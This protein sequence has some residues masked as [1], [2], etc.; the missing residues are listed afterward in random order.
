M[1][2][3]YQ[4]DSAESVVVEHQKIRKS[5]LD[6]NDHCLLQVC[7]YLD[8]WDV[9]YLSRVCKKLHAVCVSAGLQFKYFSMEDYC[10]WYGQG[11]YNEAKFIADMDSVMG[12]ICPF[13]E[14]LDFSNINDD[15]AVPY[16]FEKFNFP[17]LK[18]LAIYKSPQL[19]WI[20]NMDSI[21]ALTI[22]KV[23]QSDLREFVGS[24]T[25]LKR[26]TLRSI[27]AEVHTSEVCSF[28]EQNPN[29]ECL[30][31]G[32]AL[33]DSVGVDFFK[34]FKNL[35]TLEFV[36]GNNYRDLNF[37]LQ[38]ERL[39]ELT[40]TLVKYDMT[41]HDDFLQLIAVAN[42][43]KTFLRLLSQKKTLKSLDLKHMKYDD[44]V[45]D[46]LA[47]LNLHF[48]RMVDH[49]YINNGLFSMQLQRQSFETLRR[50]DITIPIE[51]ETLLHLIRRSRCLKLMYL[52]WVMSY[53]PDTL[54]AELIRLFQNTKE[55]IIR[56]DLVIHSM[57]PLVK[58]EVKRGKEKFTGMLY[59]RWHFLS[60]AFNSNKVLTSLG[61]PYFV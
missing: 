28:L 25:K 10:D 26:I 54:L 31:L 11:D 47:S 43:T 51:L 33:V 37:V 24:I 53:N 34:K 19:R 1:E 27:S 35:K 17:K 29:I 39:T 42:Q 52:S 48:L 36:I 23:S 9:I 5:L 7:S 4:C 14:I 32:D 45:I 22:S 21:E 15:W 16:E 18:S 40:L 41:D 55:D 46:I 38:A 57:E 50:F 49:Q 13:A 60:S 2:C 58:I 6:L 30:H 8:I 59:G 20:N 61:E 56:P 44:E 12:L 3:E